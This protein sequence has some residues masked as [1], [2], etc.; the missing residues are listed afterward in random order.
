MSTINNQPTTEDIQALQNNPLLQTEFEQKYGVGAATEYL[1]TETDKAVI[2]KDKPVEDEGGGLID[3]AVDVVTGAGKGLFYGAEETNQ[4]LN[5]IA[6]DLNIPEPLRKVGSLLTGS[7]GR[8][9]TS[10]QLS[11]AEKLNNTE[12]N[13]QSSPTEI[14][15]DEDEI[16]E[17]YD[18]TAEA[19]SGNIAQFASGFL[20]GDRLLKGFGWARSGKKSL[21]L[22]RSF[23][24]GGVADFV[25][26]DAYQ[27]RFSDFIVNTFPELENTYLDYLTSDENDTYYES[28]FKNVAEGVVL[29]GAAELLFL[30]AKGI[31]GLYKFITK[32]DPKGAAKEAESVGEQIQKELNEKRSVK[33]IKVKK[34]EAETVAI[35]TQR[36][37]Y[38]NLVKDNLKKVVQGTGEF[39]NINDAIDIP[40]DPKRLGIDSDDE[41]LI[42]T[43]ELVDNIDSLK[44]TD[45]VSHTE[46][47]EMADEFLSDVPNVVNFGYQF[48][49]DIQ[50]APAVLLANRA[51]YKGLAKHA[52]NVQRRAERG[53]VAQEE[54]I[55]IIKRAATIYSNVD[56]ILSGGGRLL[57]SAKIGTDE[58]QTTE[59]FLK[60]FIRETEIDPSRAKVMLNKWGK[61][62]PENTHFF[63]YLMR[64]Y[65]L[66]RQIVKHGNKLFINAIL[67]NPKTHAINVSSNIIMAILKPIEQIGGGIVTLNRADIMDG[68]YTMAG[69]LR[70]YKDAGRHAWNALRKGDTILDRNTTKLD[71]EVDKATTVA[72]KVVETPTRFLAAEDEFFKQINF[73]AKAYA[74]IVREAFSKKLSREKIYELPNGKKYSEFDRYVTERMEQA[75]KKNGEAADEF[76][77]ALEYA[78]EATFTKKIEQG[79]LGS[80]AQNTVNRI[81]I[82]RQIIPFVRT[83]L[84]LMSGVLDRTP[85][86]G[87]FRP[88]FVKQLRSTDAGVRAAAVGKQLFG[89][90]FIATILTQV[91]LGSITGGINRKERNLYRQK[92]DAGWRP[93]SVK[94]GDTYFSYERL[95]PLGTIIGLVADYGELAADLN[96]KDR[97]AL[98][99]TTLLS[100]IS[101]METDEPSKVAGT[102]ISK[103]LSNLTSKTY[104]KSLADF[105]EIF[106]DENPNK[107]RR[108]F[109]NK[110]G[111]FVPNII[112]NAVNDE[113][114]REARDIVDTLKIRT[115]ING[116]TASLSY[117]ALGE[118][119]LKSQ[120]LL[121]SLLNPVGTSQVT[122]DPVL[123]E[124]ANLNHG[125]T[126]ASNKIGINGNLDLLDFKDANGKSAFDAYNE[127]ITTKNLREQLGGLISSDAWKS[128]KLSYKAD[129]KTYKSNK[130]KLVERL[131]RQGRNAALNEILY[132]GKF[133]SESGLDLSQAYMHDKQN[134]YLNEL[135]KE[136][137]PTK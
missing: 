10:E 75:T 110:V 112:K 116:D 27:E 28:K 62:D 65:L 127:A 52:Y 90:A 113:Y 88:Y 134:N 19:I 67:S 118:P 46:T 122:D 103:T 21:D 54:A 109:N 100:V 2:N 39:S 55:E 135:G 76:K 33:Q 12:E 8:E 128:M 111:A 5:Q 59:N 41:L 11:E 82:A 114:L 37:D 136:L 130:I 119:R 106:T 104:L 3:T 56:R 83:P 63:N 48:G 36:T 95:D 49:R 86:I 105:M 17:R 26:F 31:K 77:E 22:T 66:P 129:D 23:V 70:Y 94:I 43:K 93:Y 137:L 24:A 81:P 7:L 61:A 60:E 35:K 16:E 101:G 14:A 117:N 68:V 51:I 18:S 32:N 92:Y 121:D 1:L 9:L 6:D 42:F 64:N 40:I 15:N 123:K 89:T 47:I 38:I 98:A 44:K 45:K 29:G 34:G 80:L 91:N 107:M 132:S 115:G 73:R 20:F 87:A 79:T 102:A 53:E 50:K 57:E 84:N 30:T 131:L 13:T 71:Y 78:Q 72:G 126:T 58:I 99:Q 97:D 124:L 74:K 25:A 125:F 4:T 133:K 120:S 108:Y 96:D 69:L 85:L